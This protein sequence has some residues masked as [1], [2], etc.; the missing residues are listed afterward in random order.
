MLGRKAE[1]ELAFE[2]VLEVDV[3]RLLSLQVELQVEWQW[4]EGGV[5]KGKEL[6][7]LVEM[8]ERYGDWIRFWCS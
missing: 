2:L 1:G 4:E 5:W 8:E 7:A 6:W 3:E